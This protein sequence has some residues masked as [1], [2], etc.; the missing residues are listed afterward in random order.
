MQIRFATPSPGGEKGLMHRVFVDFENVPSV[1]L[2]EIGGK[3]IM[4]TLLLGKAQKRLDVS[5][6][7]QIQLHAAQIDLRKM[8]ASGRN[9]LDLALAF[10]LGQAAA[11]HPEDCYHIISRDRDFEPLMAHVRSTGVRVFRHDKFSL[12]AV[13]GAGRSSGRAA[14]RPA[15]KAT[16]T[17]ERLRRSG[18][19]R[20]TRRSKLLSYVKAQIGEKLADGEAEIIVETL[21]DRGVV[22]IDARNRVTYPGITAAT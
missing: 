10:H 7:Q 11:A 16:I 21:V 22:A 15:D 1:D 14:P 12:R 3:S 19:G 9:A 6:V 5:L 20:P 8:D 18:S 13:L 2:G 4:V 17:L